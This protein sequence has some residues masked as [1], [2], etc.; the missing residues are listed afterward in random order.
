M[1]REKTV[2]LAILD[3][4]ARA[5]TLVRTGTLVLVVRRDREGH[6]DDA[7]HAGVQDLV[8]GGGLCIDYSKK[9]VALESQ[10]LVFLGGLPDFSA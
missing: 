5:G 4:E 2:R 1:N 8:N 10:S 6:R 3:R 9:T 7:A